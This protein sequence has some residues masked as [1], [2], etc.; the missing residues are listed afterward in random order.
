MLLVLGAGES[1]LGA[2]LLA[3]AKG[4]NVF[5]SDKNTIN[6][7]Y[8]KQLLAYNIPFE[9]NKNSLTYIQN[10]TEIIKSPGIA[11]SNPTILFAK[12][13][14]I[15]IIDEIE[16]AFRHTKAML[17]AVTGS[18]GKSTT[19]HLLHYLL[20]KLG[21]KSV[22]VGNVGNS[23]AKQLFKDPHYDYFIIELSSFQLEYIHKF[24]PHIATV[25]NISPDHLDR[26]QNDMVKYIHA[27]MSILKNMCAKN[28]F[29]FH[30][31]EKY[32]NKFL[33]HNKISTQIIKLQSTKK[34]LLYCEVE[35]KYITI[36]KNSIKL[37]GIHNYY[38]ILIALKIVNLLN[39]SLSHIQK[40]LST[41]YG[42]PH[43][44][45]WVGKLKNINIYN[46]AKA[47]NIDA[48]FHA[49]MCFNQSIIWIAGGIDKGNNYMP[50]KKEVGKKV[51]A[52]ICLGKDNKNLIQ[53]FQEY[54]PQIFQTTSMQRACKIAFSL[55]QNDD[56]ILLS[57]ACSSLDLYKNFEEKGDFF[58]KNIL[59]FFKKNTNF[60]K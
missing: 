14:K 19:V 58:K 22:L 1:G 21:K 25:L 52:L 5:V 37:P 47:T 15:P 13:R 33:G 59:F 29:V 55:A 45:E 11:E 27:K 24:K 46:D 26:Y 36:K 60:S 18:N 8:K 20:N 57:P 23:F 43:R 7:Y 51:K 28:Y 30:K 31:K 10:A 39:F 54:I 49:F 9:E 4:Y 35:K 6:Y 56:I 44:L 32:I 17:I 2:A 50:L 42:L 3:K 41:F 16:F 38:N 53:N 48:V 40:Y 12:K 34:F